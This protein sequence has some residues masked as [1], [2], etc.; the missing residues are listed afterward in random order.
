MQTLNETVR[1]EADDRPPL[2]LTAG[3]GLQYTI[4]SLASVV[5][6]PVVLITVVGE[7][8]AYLSWALFA[9][10]IVSGVATTVQSIRIGRVGAG[11]ILVMG[12]TSAFLPVSVTA[13]EQGGPGLMATLI[14]CSSLIQFLLGAKM[15]MLRRVFT[16][17][18]AGTVLML[19]PISVAPIILRKV[20]DVPGGVSELAA[21]VALIATFA[22]IVLVA[23]RFSNAW[24]IWSPAIGILVGCGLGFAFGIYDV[25]RVVDAPWIGLPDFSAHPGL[26]LQ[27]DAVF[28]GLLPGFLIITLVGA[29]DTLGDSIAIQ[30]AS[31]RKPRAIDFRSIQGAI[32]ADGLGNLLSGLG[33]TVPNTTYGNSIAI[34]ELTGVAA[35]SVGV[36]VGVLFVALAFLPKLVAVAVAIPGP[37]VAAYFV[38]LMALLFIFGVKILVNDGLDYQKSLI[39]GSGFCVGLACQFDLVFPELLDGP[40][41]RMLSH[42][43]T[44]GGLTVILLHGILDL[45]SAR[46]RRL[47]TDLSTAKLSE[48]DRFLCDVASRMKCDESMTH[49][50]RA[51][52]EET[53]HTLLG[54][55]ADDPVRR[56]LIV[57]R[58]DGRAVS[59]E[60]MA[61]GGDL[62]LEDQLAMLGSAEKDWPS[63]AETPLRL[64][65]HYATTVGHQQFHDTDIVTA[66]LEPEGSAV[67]K[68]T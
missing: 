21:P 13:L 64:L 41:G 25:Q 61:S 11:Y 12:S 66:R 15:A 48:I 32:N 56:L 31:W 17:T 39:V 20:Q 46:P 10:L 50:L 33:G 2:F 47:R 18:V 68:P 30:R 6:A 44:A 14:V 36:C 62:N 45:T 5:L 1:Y 42:G 63:E 51:V 52:A 54:N 38:V 19:I 22:T 24:R 58:A 60:F 65:R 55:G 37:V 29:M 8:E 40:W 3:L 53:V 67:G 4:L 7:S 16:P 9:A 26:D 43:M 28:W 35:R 34:A 57:A 23:L 59:V 27:F 49:R